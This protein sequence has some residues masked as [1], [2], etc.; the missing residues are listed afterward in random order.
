MPRH[1]DADADL[2]RGLHQ[3]VFKDA[4]F[5]SA[6]AAAFEGAR[7]ELENEENALP[8]SSAEVPPALFKGKLAKDL[9]NKVKLCRVFILR[10]ARRLETP[11]VHRNSIQRLTSYQGRGTIHSAAPGGQDMDFKPY[12]LEDPEQSL[13]TDLNKVWDVV[14]MNTWHSPEA[15]AEGDWHTVTFHSAT[16]EEII[17]EYAPPTRR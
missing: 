2:V 4:K 11:E 8:Y 7:T 13:I 17:D 16:S 14:P 10:R 6:L 12:V 3:F 1:P 9:R 5:R 15:S